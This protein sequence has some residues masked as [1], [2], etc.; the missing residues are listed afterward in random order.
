MI[1]G[2]LARADTHGFQKYIINHNVFCKLTNHLFTHDLLIIH[3]LVHICMRVCVCV[4]VCEMTVRLDGD[5]ACAC[6]CV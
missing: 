5:S 4:C 3:V 2:R 6:V 1:K